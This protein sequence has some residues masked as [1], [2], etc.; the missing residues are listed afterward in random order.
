MRRIL[1]AKYEK[2]DINKVMTEQCKQLIPI[3]RE[4]PLNPLKIFEY[5]SDGI[6]GKWN[7]A[8]VDLESNDD[9]KPVCTRPY[10]VPRVHMAMFRK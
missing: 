4:I 3:E 1:D 5:F 10:P 6:L 9:A 8:P 2:A 7:S